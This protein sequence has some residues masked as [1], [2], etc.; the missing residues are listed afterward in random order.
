[1]ASIDTPFSSRPFTTSSCTRNGIENGDSAAVLL[2]KR[3]DKYAL[4]TVKRTP[5]YAAASSGHVAAALTRMAVGADVSHQCI[6]SMRSVL[7]GGS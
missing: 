6:E 7:H 4:D 3:A 2:R 1:M 5:L